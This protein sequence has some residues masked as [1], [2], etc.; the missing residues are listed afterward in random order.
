[1]VDLGG[2]HW[3][4]PREVLLTILGHVRLKLRKSHGRLFWGTLAK[5]RE[6]WLTILGHVG[7]KQREPL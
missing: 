7:L 2:A 5:S 3:L 4:K 6:L 1:M